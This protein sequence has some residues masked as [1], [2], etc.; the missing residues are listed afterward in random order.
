MQM[1]PLCLNNDI[2]FFCE[3]KKRVYRRCRQC[4]LVFVEDKFILSAEDEKAIYDLHENDVNDQG[5]R[6]F[7]SRL[8]NPLLERLS[9]GSSGLDFGCGPG[10][11]LAEMMKEAGHKMSLYDLYYYPDQ[12]TLEQKYDFITS[13]EVVEHIKDSQKLFDTFD[14]LLNDKGTLGLMTKL[15]IDQ[16]AFSK[17]HY[18]NDQTHIRFFSEE[19]FLWIAKKY[20]MKVNFF[21][22]DVI[23]FEK[24][25]S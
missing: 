8:V 25:N 1:C 6:K 14:T 20:E 7:L 12:S 13:T 19:T 3:D 22:K 11:A 16:N 18:K 10:P 21:N 4:L 24:Q 17:W 5:Y 9:P 23:I 2:S 15:V